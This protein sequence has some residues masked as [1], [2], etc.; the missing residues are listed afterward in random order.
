[1]CLFF[2][3]SVT[4]SL[5][6]MLCAGWQRHEF[7]VIFMPVKLCVNVLF[8]L[9]KKLVAREDIARFCD[10]WSLTRLYK[11]IYS[12][13]II[14]QVGLG[15][16]RARERERWTERLAHT[17]RWIPSRNY[18]IAD[19]Q[20][21]YIRNVSSIFVVVVVVKLTTFSISHWNEQKI[22]KGKNERKKNR[23]NFSTML[24]AW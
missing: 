15:L 14:H 5:S 8:V 22:K 9:S 17:F 19:I 10:V 18:F 20:T 4:S 23:L 3:S 24:T 7:A 6:L 11:K 2:F 13:V 16:G 1:M 12:K 21:L